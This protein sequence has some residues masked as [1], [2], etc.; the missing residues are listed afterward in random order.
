MRGILVASIAVV[1]RSPADLDELHRDC[2]RRALHRFERRTSH[3]GGRSKADPYN[4]RTVWV[5]PP[6]E[7]ASARFV[8]GG[9]PCVS[10]PSHRSDRSGVL[11]LLLL[12]TFGIDLLRFY[13]QHRGLKHGINSQ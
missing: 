6:T 1:Q 13:S 8:P 9:M 3:A 12:L 4:V 2:Y 11:P 10:T 7:T 5:S